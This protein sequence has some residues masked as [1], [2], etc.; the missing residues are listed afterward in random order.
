MGVCKGEC[1]GYSLEDESLMLMR[2]HSC[3]MPQL[4]E[5]LEGWK[6]VCGQA[7]NLKGIKGKISVFLLFLSFVS[8]LLHSSHGTMCADPA[9]A[10]GGD[11]LINK[12]KYI[13]GTI[14]R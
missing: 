14:L 8:I 2:C 4:Y 6:F 9:V 12:Y 5:T 3:G 10:G 11:C 7:Y 1:M 13:L